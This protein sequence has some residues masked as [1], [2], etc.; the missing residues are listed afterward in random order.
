M[1][2]SP[3]RYLWYSN[4]YRVTRTMQN[5]A[6]AWG[7]IDCIILS[8]PFAIFVFGHLHFAASSFERREPR[9]DRGGL[10]LDERVF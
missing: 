1:Q 8:L 3:V 9:L 5:T 2:R 10:R 4:S 7:E 6:Q